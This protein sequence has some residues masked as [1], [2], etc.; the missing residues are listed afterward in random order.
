MPPLLP[1]THLVL[2]M[3]VWLKAL[4]LV[5]AQALLDERLTAASQCADKQVYRARGIEVV[6]HTT[7]PPIRT[8]S[9]DVFHS[10]I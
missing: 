1:T 4:S 7:S 10:V 2:H 6:S 8:L 3:C 9:I 5:C